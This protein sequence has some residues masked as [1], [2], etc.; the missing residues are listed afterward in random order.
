MLEENQLN[1]DYWESRYLLGQTGWDAGGIT[2]PLR[3]YFDGLASRSLKILIPGAGN[4]YEAEYL[5]KAGFK[6]VHVLDIAP[7][8]LA[9][10]K[11]RVPD[12]P[13]QHLIQADFFELEGSYDL[14]IEQTFFCALY[15]GLRKAYARK[16]HELLRPGG[17]LA[18]VLFDDAL[19]QDRPPFG[20][21]AQ[22][23]LEYFQPYFEIKTFEKAYNSISPRAGRELF[24]QLKKTEK[25][26]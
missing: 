12:F 19:N 22:E 16:M 14:I 6:Q 4:A 26:V 1:A 20:G 5:H 11:Q 2:T 7:S 9:K 23:Y 21:S 25:E 10:I 13:E 3:T 8:P 15:P 18:G 17:M 24:I